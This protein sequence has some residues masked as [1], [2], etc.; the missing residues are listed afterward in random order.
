MACVAW[1]G[2]SSYA[3][4]SPQNYMA[5]VAWCGIGY[6]EFMCT[7]TL[8]DFRV[9]LLH[10]CITVKVMLFGGLPDEN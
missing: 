8:T 1:C 3:H 5:C 9:S 6:Q 4:R 10:E 7:G 2:I